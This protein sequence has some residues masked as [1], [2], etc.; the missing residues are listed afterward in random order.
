MHTVVR[1]SGGIVAVTAALLLFGAGVA[2]AHVT[3][4]APGVSVGQSDAAITFRVPDESATAS[5]V[6][7]KVQLPTATPIAGVLVAP[8][9][10]WTATMVNTKLAKPIT[11]DDGTITEVVSEI[12]WTADTGAGIKPGFFGQFTIIGGQLPDAVNT[13]TFRAIQT[14]SDRTVVSWIEQAAPGS[15]VEPDHPAPELTLLPAAAGPS[16][17]A[18]GAAASGAVATSAAAATAQSSVTTGVA[19]TAAPMAMA[20]ADVATKSSVTWATVIGVV[21]L[22]VGIAGVGMALSARRRRDVV[23]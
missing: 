6:G 1:K 23:K 19:V 12:D 5:T 13:L 10:G 14:Y 21:G 8:V 4:A 9:T 22:L 16:V 11:T 15:T 7:L 18:S 17:A 20:D 3:V 2:S